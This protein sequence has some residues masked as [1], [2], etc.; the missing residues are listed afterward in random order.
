MADAGYNMVHFAPVNARGISNSPYAIFDQMQLSDDLFDPIVNSKS[1]TANSGAHIKFPSEQEKEVILT[2]MLNIIW[3]D[4]GIISVTDV[5]WNHTAC[6]SEWL[7]DHPEA[8]SFNNLK[9]EQLLLLN[10]NLLP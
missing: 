4:H 8:V 6:N 10:Q 9:M 3:R 2:D 1:T 5:V 7:E